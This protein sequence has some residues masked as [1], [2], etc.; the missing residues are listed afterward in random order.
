MRNFA[1]ISVFFLVFMALSSCAN[2]GSK[3]NGEDTTTQSQ[4]ENPEPDSNKNKIDSSSDTS[5][6][7]VENIAE[8]PD[9]A[10]LRTGIESAELVATLSGPGP[11]TIFAP[12]DTAF[13]IA[14]IRVKKLQSSG[15]DKKLQEVLTY[16]ILSGFYTTDDLKSGME[17]STVEGKKIRIEIQDRQYMING[18]PITTRNIIAKNG[19]I[20]VIDRVLNPADSVAAVEP[21]KP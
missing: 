12:I 7:I 8:R 4:L 10:I 5:K 15:P 3:E 19:V 9:M 1:C 13:K 2:R 18:V 20:H 6:T 11:F 16:H 14:G 21:Q 17:L